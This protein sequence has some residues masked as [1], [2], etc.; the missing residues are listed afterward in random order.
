MRRVL[1]NCLSISC[2]ITKW[3]NYSS[4][5]LVNVKRLSRLFFWFV[6]F[7]PSAQ[8][9]ISPHYIAFNVSV[10]ILSGAMISQTS[11]HGDFR[12]IWELPGTPE[13]LS[14]ADVLGASALADG[15]DAS[16]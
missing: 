14:R 9:G 2:T 13:K 15:L 1:L 6:P 8:R 4:R 5:R 7:Q 11:G 3:D 10:A 16:P 12:Y